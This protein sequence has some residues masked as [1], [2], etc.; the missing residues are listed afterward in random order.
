M[1]GKPTGNCCHVPI[2]LTNISN[3]KTRSF[4]F[5]F[6][7]QPAPNRAPT[8]TLRHTLHILFRYVRL[9]ATMFNLKKQRNPPTG[10]LTTPPL[11]TGRDRPPKSTPRPAPR[12]ETR[13]VVDLH[14]GG[15]DPQL[16]PVP[17]HPSL[18]LE[19]VLRRKNAAG[20]LSR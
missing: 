2:P 4:S 5:G 8:P 15:P 12:T 7:L 14:K 13:L 11:Q 6:P 1:E 20:P 18:L 3:G 17:G 9:F 16:V 10:P 19:E